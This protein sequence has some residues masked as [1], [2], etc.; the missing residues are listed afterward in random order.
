MKVVNQMKRIPMIVKLLI[1]VVMLKVL[2]GT[3]EGMDNQYG[4]GK[5][6]IKTSNCTA[7]Q[8]VIRDYILRDEQQNTIIK[9]CD[10]FDTKNDFKTAVYEFIEKR[11][12]NTEQLKAWDKN[13][14]GTLC[15]DTHN[16]RKGKA[17]REVSD[18]YMMGGR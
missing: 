13:Q 14:D 15:K 5:G 10:D 11:S 7:E 9:K 12:H 17:I 2:M 4:L 6:P 8:K 16:V 1:L 18:A 3:R